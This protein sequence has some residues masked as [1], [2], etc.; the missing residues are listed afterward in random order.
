MSLT[1]SLIAAVSAAGFGSAPPAL[2]DI[3]LFP[4]ERASTFASVGVGGIIDRDPDGSLP[5]DQAELYD[6]RPSLRL[7]ASGFSIDGWKASFEGIPGATFD[8]ENYLSRGWVELAIKNRGRETEYRLTLEDRDPSRRQGTVFGVQVAIPSGDWSHVK[9]P[10]REIVRDPSVFRLRQTWRLSLTSRREASLL[11]GSVAI[12]SPDPE[13]LPHPIKAN[14]WGWRPS[15]E[16]KVLLTLP[17]GVPAPAGWRVTSGSG[18]Q[19]LSGRWREA[20]KLDPLSGGSLWTADLTPLRSLGEHRLSSEG[21][22]AAPLVLTLRSRPYR[23][24]FEAALL[25]LSQMRTKEGTWTG[26]IESHLASLRI[27]LWTL[28]LN[29][30]QGPSDLEREVRW[31]LEGVASILNPSEEAKEVLAHGAMV[32]ARRDQQL[33]TRLAALAGGDGPARR[34]LRKEAPSSDAG[35]P[36]GWDSLHSAAAPG[37]R[38]SLLASADRV[39][40]AAAA[41][42]WGITLGEPESFERQSSHL[43][44]EKPLLAATARRVLGRESWRSTKSVQSGL[45]WVLGRS[46]LGMSLVT[47]FGSQS[48]ANPVWP[49]PWRAPSGLLV[50]GQAW[51]EGRHYSRFVGRRHRDVPTD[52]WVNGVSAN[53]CALLVMAAALLD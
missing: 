28:E 30:D 52:P 8:I 27:L 29:L 51:S 3:L 47:G 46:P 12:K 22:D 43:I 42:P 40:A 39:D 19:V 31:G 9:V 24:L 26:G 25:A 14:L 41:H 44:L 50:S 34:R 53:G 45:E 4:G 17:E 13:P 7:L 37:L 2:P 16:K 33:S 49:M 1:V 20:Q 32:F 36:L 10:I 15:D 21:L 11:I 35:S 18:R 6:G 48:V 38:A 5:L 23:P